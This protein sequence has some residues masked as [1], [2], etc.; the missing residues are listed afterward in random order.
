MSECL[1]HETLRRQGSPCPYC[2]IKEL[3]SENKIFRATESV[4]DTVW[5]ALLEQVRQRDDRLGAA[6]AKIDALMME[7]CVDEMTIEQWGNWAKHQVPISIEEQKELDNA[8][9]DND[10]E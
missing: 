3:V 7:Y 8:L 6:Q 5:D 9:E 4:D 2:R 10:S 1:K